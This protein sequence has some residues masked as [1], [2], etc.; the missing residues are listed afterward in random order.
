MSVRGHTQ[1]TKAA[2]VLA[3][4]LNH[5]RG[6]FPPRGKPLSRWGPWS[7][8]R[9]FSFALDQIRQAIE[10]HFSLQQTLYPWNQIAQALAEKSRD[11]LL[12]LTILLL[13]NAFDL[14]QSRSTQK[15]LTIQALL[16]P[17]TSASNIP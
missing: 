3:K 1:L 9:E 10:P 15:F 8:C 4:L 11:R 13:L 14:S 12:P 16:S 17:G 6:R 5:A 2:I 7:P